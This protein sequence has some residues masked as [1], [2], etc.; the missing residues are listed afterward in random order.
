MAEL[1]FLL[2]R[3]LLGLLSP[4]IIDAIRAKC[5]RRDLAVAI[6][7]EA[8]DLQYRVAATSFRLAQW[9]GEVS[10]D[11]LIWLK[12]KVM[13]YEGNEPVQSVRA[14]ARL[15]RFDDESTFFHGCAS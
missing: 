8:Q 6:R 14:L 11:Y 9:Y 7:S 4:R 2:L 10:R 12:P 5:L 13:Q 3:W 15:G 1:P